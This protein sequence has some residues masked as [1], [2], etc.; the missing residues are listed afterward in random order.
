MTPHRS[1]GLGVEPDCEPARSV[2][3]RLI[4]HERARDALASDLGA[5]A[6]QVWRSPDGMVSAVCLRRDGQHWVEVPGVA[7]F[8]SSIDDR[9]C[10]TAIPH[11]DA[12]LDEVVDTYRRS[13]VPLLLQALGT[14]VLHASAAL[15][16]DGVIGCCG[17]ARTGK[18]TL[19]FALA[20][21]GYPVWADDALAVDLAT[22]PVTTV[23][24]PCEVR[25]R[26]S[27]T[28]YFEG[29]GITPGARMAPDG[30]DQSPQPL[31]ALV[32]LARSTRGALTVERLPPAR[33][34]AALL[35]H[36]YCFSLQQ[37]DDKRRLLERYLALATRVPVYR[38]EF[39][40]RFDVL[41]DTVLAL[42]RLGASLS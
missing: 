39:E 9:G 28:V 30:S 26:P 35:S 17:A 1:S 14:E 38:L 21:R 29:R 42:E 37:T 25:L 23:A 8:F 2:V 13:A 33:A 36:A 34:F 41:P 27:A 11:P 19:V 6:T 7:R 40:P 24:L 5:P 22:E 18:S 4:V 16:A 20:Q 15:T 10:V 12:R 3:P 31:S 32:V